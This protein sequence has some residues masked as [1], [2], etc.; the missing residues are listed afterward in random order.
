MKT[1]LVLL[2]CL[3]SL[4]SLVLRGGGVCF[5]AATLTSTPAIGEERLLAEAGTNDARFTELQFRLQRFVD[6]H[7]IPAMSVAFTYQGKIRYARGFGFADRERLI[8]VTSKSLFRIASVSKPITAVAIMQLT[9]KGRCALEDRVFEILEDPQAREKIG[10]H[11]DRRLDAITLRM[12][13]EHRAGW[14]RDVSLDPMFRSAHFARIEGVRGPA[15]AEVVIR[16]MLRQPLDFSPGQRY[17][18]SNFGY[19]LLGRVIEKVSGQPYE[20]YVREHVLQPLG[21]SAMRIGGT[22]PHEREPDEVAYF[23]SGVAPSIYPEDH[24]M[25]R[26]APDG[27][28]SLEAMDAH[29]GWIASA[30]DL[31]I[32]SIA[33]DDPERS[34]ILSHESIQRMFAPPSIRDRQEDPHLYY[35][36]GWQNRYLPEHQ[37]YNRWHSGSLPGTLA[38]LIRGHQ[39]ITMVALTNTRESPHTGDLALALDRILWKAVGSVDSWEP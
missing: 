13:L 33:F 23:D 5:W 38:I 21:I 7:Q 32:F 17:A 4:L 30:V 11:Y 36:L 34:P 28:W 35:S 16:G 25:L 1:P 14:D 39:G 24:G 3:G 10:D 37:Q 12:L 8:P 29:G 19:C 9:E 26:P 18:Y 31:A 2:R 27:T 6:R 15:T 20:T 22:Q